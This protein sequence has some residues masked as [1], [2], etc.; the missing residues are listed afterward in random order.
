MKSSTVAPLPDTHNRVD[1]P[2]GSTKYEVALSPPKDLYLR[3][4]ITGS[5]KCTLPIIFIIL[6]KPVSNSMDGQDETQEQ[7]EQ[8]AGGLLLYTFAFGCWGEILEKFEEAAGPVQRRQWRVY[9][10][11]LLAALVCSPLFYG[12]F[13]VDWGTSLFDYGVTGKCSRW[14]SNPHPLNGHVGQLREE[15]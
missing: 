15:D 11:I 4:L 8:I 1:A 3:M 10:L 5:L 12:A 9:G 13:E 14:G 6:S 2:K 7:F